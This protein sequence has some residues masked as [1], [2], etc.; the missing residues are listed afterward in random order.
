M[1]TSLPPE[2]DSDRI[3]PRHLAWAALAI[4]TLLYV[5]S[6]LAMR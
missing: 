4:A 1:G 2:D 3:E 6:Y 5:M